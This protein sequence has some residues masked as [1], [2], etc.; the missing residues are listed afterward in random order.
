MLS[1][2]WC[3]TTKEAPVPV[4]RQ[5]HP[6][7]G[8]LASDKPLAIEHLSTSQLRHLASITEDKY[9]AHGDRVLLLDVVQE[10]LNSDLSKHWQVENGKVYGG[11]AACPHH[12]LSWLSK[13]CLSSAFRLR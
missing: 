9:A 11:A 8:Q 2:L 12:M 6:L 5:T 7:C 1:W 10:K 4:S 13:I 3:T